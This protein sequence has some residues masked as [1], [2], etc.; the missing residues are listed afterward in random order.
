MT[1]FLINNESV[2]LYDTLLADVN[3]AT[4]YYNPYR[5][6]VLYHF[7]LNLIVALAA[8]KPLLLIDSDTND[9]ELDGLDSETINESSP[10]SKLNFLSIEDLLR[11]IQTSNSLSK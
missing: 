11:K 9:N 1:V 5:T 6:S 3:N 8:D 10:I 4:K 7:F 2:H